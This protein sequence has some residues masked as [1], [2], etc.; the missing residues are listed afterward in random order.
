MKNYL[1]ALLL[2][3][4]LVMTVL[5]TSVAV[6]EPAEGEEPVMTSSYMEI[7]PKTEKMAD[8]FESDVKR[9]RIKQRTNA[10]LNA[11]IRLAAYKLK[12][13][14]HKKEADKMIYEWEHQY[15]LVLEGRGIGD[16][17]PLSNW[18]A[19]KTAMLQFILGKEV[20]HALRLDDLITINYA[21]PVVISCVDNVD[22]EEYGNHFVEDLDNGYRGLGP[23]VVYW[24]SF[25]SCMSFSWGVGFLG[26]A[27]IALGSEWLTLNFVAPRLNPVLW[28]LAC[29]RL[30]L[31]E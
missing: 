10:A 12:R 15:S 11:A 28:N 7:S 3:V 22:L 25:F 19:E 18:L 9:G 16:H 14:G 21:L 29:N 24:T 17:K 5:K 23:V 31:Y 1:P 27:P 30:E 26:C 2:S 6:A 8:K 13:V 20:M 4:C